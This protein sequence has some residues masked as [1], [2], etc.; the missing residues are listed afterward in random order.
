MALV[1]LLKSTEF[2]EVD[3][4]VLAVGEKAYG[5]GT[6]H[7]GRDRQQPPA[8]SPPTCRSYGKSTGLD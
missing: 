7:V 2:S 3:K 6:E 1:P 5:K 4:H 8:C